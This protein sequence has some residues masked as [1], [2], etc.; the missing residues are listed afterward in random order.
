MTECAQ[1]YM[2]QVWFIYNKNLQVFQLDATSMV[3]IHLANGFEFKYVVLI[4]NWATKI[5]MMTTFFKVR[6]FPVLH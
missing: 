5:H 4:A 2:P 6:L 3:Y 1:Q